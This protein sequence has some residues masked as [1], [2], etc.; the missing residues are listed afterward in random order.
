M[1]LSHPAP[2][3]GVKPLLL[4]R[5]GQHRRRDRNRQLV[6]FPSE[7]EWKLIALIVPILDPMIE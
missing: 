1:W 4:A 7:G 3:A 5:F 6:D 2:R